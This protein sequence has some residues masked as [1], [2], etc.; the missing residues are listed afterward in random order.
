MTSIE[1]GCPY[2]FFNAIVLE[3]G[4][5]YIITK[6]CQYTINC[7]LKVR[8]IGSSIVDSI[9]VEFFYLPLGCPR[10]N[11][12]ATMEGAVSLT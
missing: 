2:F 3:Q 5:C 1:A 8:K 6:N 11:F 4:S 10:V 12:W 7:F 9:L